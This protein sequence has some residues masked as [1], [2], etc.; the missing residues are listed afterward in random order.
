MTNIDG[1]QWNRNAQSIKIGEATI[2]FTPTEYRLLSPLIQG[3]PITYE[4]LARRAY[5]YS[6]DNKVRAMMDKHIDRIRGK[7]RG[8]GMYIYCVLNYGYILLPEHPLLDEA[9]SD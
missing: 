2:I 7:L 8:T 5:N 3:T 4:I 1:V 6:I 9:A